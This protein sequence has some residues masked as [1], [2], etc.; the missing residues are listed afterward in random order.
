M[1]RV[2]LFLALSAFVCLGVIVAGAHGQNESAA[3]RMVEAPVQIIDVTGSEDDPNPFPL[4]FIPPGACELPNGDCVVTLD[5]IC[6]ILGGEFQ[7][8]NTECE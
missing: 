7:G 6:R 3:G 8:G 4:P 2:P 5:T 1:R